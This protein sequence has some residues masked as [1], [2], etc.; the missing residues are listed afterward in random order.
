MTDVLKRRGDENTD[1]CTQVK[2]HKKTKR[3]DGYLQ[4][5]K[6]GLRMKPT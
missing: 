5:K 4:A 3:E 2:D 1:R 6:I